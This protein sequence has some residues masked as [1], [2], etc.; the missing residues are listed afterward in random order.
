MT[1]DQEK[2]SPFAAVT[3]VEASWDCVTKLLSSESWFDKLVGLFNLGFVPVVPRQGS[4]GASGDLA[5]LAHMA[6]AY[7]G[8][9]EAYWKGE[10]VP[11]ERRAP[12]EFPLRDEEEES[13]VG[14][15]EGGAGREG[16]G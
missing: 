13:A 6:A 3:A 4:V 12:A 16:D 7:M 5:P 11:V 15:P 14:E 9:G 1:S 8:H 2:G 10:V